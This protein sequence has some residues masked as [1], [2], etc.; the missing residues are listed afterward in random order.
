MCQEAYIKCLNRA[1]SGHAQTLGLVR[2]EN[3]PHCEIEYTRVA[4]RAGI[5]E[6]YCADCRRL[7]KQ[8]RQKEVK[9]RRERIRE[10]ARAGP[11][12]S[13]ASGANE[14][15]QQA[16]SSRV[17]EY[18]G[19]HLPSSGTVLPSAREGPVTS[20]SSIG[21]NG[22]L[23]TA[24]A[25]RYTTA[26]YT[27]EYRFVPT[28]PTTTPPRTSSPFPLD[29]TPEP[30]TTNPPTYTP[31]STATNA[32]PGPLTS[33]ESQVPVDPQILYAEDACG[34]A[35]DGEFPAPGI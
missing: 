11:R 20:F 23:P 9:A 18:E 25:Y 24:T 31:P 35:S 2:C 27:C 17:G 15:P 1:C 14:T 6:P 7:T 34:N 29:F 30:Y 13:E 3:S 10:S 26:N 33:S 12:N 21:F 28:N 19:E 16:E 4:R 32:G 22:E 8:Q 5:T